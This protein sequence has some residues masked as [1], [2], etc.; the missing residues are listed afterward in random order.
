MDSP[1]LLTGGTGTLGRLV[2]RACRMPARTS[3]CSAGKATRPATASS[4]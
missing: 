2:L 1:I 4:T 3:G